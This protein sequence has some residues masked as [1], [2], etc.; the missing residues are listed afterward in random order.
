MNVELQNEIVSHVFANFGVF[1][2]TNYSL[3][4]DKYLLNDKLSFEEGD[5]QIWGI[6]I[7][8]ESQE[9]KVLLGNCTLDNYPEF[10]LIVQMKNCPFYSLLLSKEDSMIYYSLNGKDWL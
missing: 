6:Q 7:S 5:R 4:D 2:A 8:S 9:I 1:T 10:C 3:I